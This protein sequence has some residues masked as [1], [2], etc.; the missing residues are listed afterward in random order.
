MALTANYDWGGE[1]CIGCGIGYGYLHRI[2]VQQMPNAPI[3]VSSP[4]PSLNSSTSTAG[5]PEVPLVVPSTPSQDDT[6]NEN[7]LEKGIA[8]ISLDSSLVTTVSQPSSTVSQ[9]AQS[10]VQSVVSK[11]IDVTQSSGVPLTVVTQPAIVPQV[12]PSSISQFTTP[13]VVPQITRPIPSTGGISLPVSPVPVS[14]GSSITPLQPPLM[15]NIPR[16]TLPS[17]GS[18]T[19]ST[20]N[21]LSTGSPPPVVNLR[22]NSLPN[23]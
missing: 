8:Q 1:G 20:I 2:P 14:I 12:V 17:T 15:D 18:T 21:F 11:S 3:T 23:N 9:V 16:I 6:V 19:S 5:L 7:E 4:Q 10:V 13:S 22:E